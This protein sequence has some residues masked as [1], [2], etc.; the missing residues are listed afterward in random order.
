MLEC[1]IEIYELVAYLDIFYTGIS[2]IRV[3][4][5]LARIDKVDS[6]YSK[7]FSLFYYLSQ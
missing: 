2:L 6:R 1:R 3:K 4:K 5:K 7:Y